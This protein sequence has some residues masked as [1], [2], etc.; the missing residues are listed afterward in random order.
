MTTN[1]IPI[2]EN[3]LSKS[4]RKKTTAQ[5]DWKP[6]AEKICAAFYKGV[7]SVIETGR[8]LNEAKETLDHGSFEAMVRLKLPFTPRTA[9]M[10]MQIAKHPVISN[11]KHVSLLPPSW[12]T[13][14]QITRLPLDLVKECVGDK[15]INP[16]TER[17]DIAALAGKQP[18][19]KTRNAA[20]IPQSKGQAKKLTRAA[21]N[22][23]QPYPVRDEVAADEEIGLLREFAKFVIERTNS[24]S[25]DPADHAEWKVLRDRVKAVLS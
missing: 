10:F 18:K 14:Y 24:V 7:A 12:G 2:D 4:Q 6:W 20:A 15:R 16:K 1:I 11:P 25:V 19:K 9:Q 5:A 13:L 3:Q 23:P 8:L 22:V 21:L 17:K